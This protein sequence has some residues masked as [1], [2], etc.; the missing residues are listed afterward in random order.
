MI[1]KI[2]ALIAANVEAGGN[3]AVKGGSDGI[4]KM[5]ENVF[6]LYN[7]RIY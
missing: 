6:Y 2:P 1:F 4:S 7:F 5:E 3:G